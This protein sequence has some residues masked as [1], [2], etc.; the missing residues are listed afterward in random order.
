MRDCHFTIR[1]H[2]K[3]LEG[4]VFNKKL[5]PA[6]AAIILFLFLEIPVA[7]GYW[8]N[9]MEPKETCSRVSNL[10]NQAI[11]YSDL[12]FCDVMIEEQLNAYVTPIISGFDGMYSSTDLRRHCYDIVFEEVT[13]EDACLGLGEKYDPCLG[14]APGVC[15]SVLVNSKKKCFYNLAK[16][17]NNPKYCGYMPAPFFHNPTR[18]A[19]CFRSTGGFLGGVVFST[20]VVIF[21]LKEAILLYSGFVGLFVAYF[22]LF[23]TVAKL[24]IVLYQLIKVRA[25]LLSIP[26]AILLLISL[27]ILIILWLSEVS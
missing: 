21:Q 25:K 1:S 16:N 10:T 12:S 19:E 26:V 8:E 5:V 18:K 20:V 7:H 4:Y 6:L 13:H 22:V 14:A 24:S 9:C 11:K 2:E 27:L 23:V 15:G 3:S 17:T